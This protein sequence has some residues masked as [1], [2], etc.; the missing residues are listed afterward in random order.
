M[1]ARPYTRKKKKRVQFHRWDIVCAL[2]QKITSLVSSAFNTR[3]SSS[4]VYKM[5]G[6]T[7]CWVK[8]DVRG[9]GGILYLSVS[10]LSGPP[11]LNI[12]YI[13]IGHC[14]GRHLHLCM[15]ADV[16]LVYVLHT[17]S[18]PRRQ[19]YLQ[20]N[21]VDRISIQH[22]CRYPITLGLYVRTDTWGRAEK[23]KVGGHR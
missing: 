18:L 4:L 10:F 22:Y 2:S 23:L 14:I 21:D 7:K 3:W 16:I 8:H 1:L 20:P 17:I 6:E 15:H 11:F 5:L 9:R 12:N 13:Y 19:L